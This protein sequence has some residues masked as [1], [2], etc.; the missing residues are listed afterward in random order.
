MLTHSLEWL[1]FGYVT[2]EKPNKNLDN[3][4]YTS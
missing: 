4:Y 3:E 2:F 1:T